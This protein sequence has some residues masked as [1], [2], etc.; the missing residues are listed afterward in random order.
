MAKDQVKEY[1]KHQLLHGIRDDG[2]NI[3]EMARTMKKDV[4]LKDGDYC[5]H[6]CA[7]NN[8]LWAMDKLVLRGFDYN[9]K[10]KHGWTALHIACMR[11][12]KLSIDYLLS[13]PNIDVNTQTNN[14]STPMHLLIE[15]GN[16]INIA[17]LYHHKEFKKGIKNSKGET[18]LE[19]MLRFGVFDELKDYKEEDKNICPA[20]INKFCKK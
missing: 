20:I 19:M 5:I 15:R 10:N 11:N 7:Y 2:M 14:L 18:E 8:N 9:R 16:I 6:I 13:L 12:F 3:E 4:E 17:R 1:I